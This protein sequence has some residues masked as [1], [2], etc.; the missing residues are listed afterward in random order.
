MYTLDYLK[1][2][3]HTN[4]NIKL[5]EVRLIKR[6]INHEEITPELIYN[7]GSVWSISDEKVKFGNESRNIKQVNR[8]VVLLAELNQFNKGND[9]EVAPGTSKYHKPSETTLVAKVPP[10]RLRKTTYFLLHYKRL[11]SKKSL[12]RKLCELSPSLINELKKFLDKTNAI[13]KG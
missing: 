10:E 3:L 12:I 2:K 1:K 4:R 8:P 7:I 6:I 13:K 9:I 5:I 11:V